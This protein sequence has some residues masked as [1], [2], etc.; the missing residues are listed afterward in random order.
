[1]TRLLATAGTSIAGQI[2][3]G[4][5]FVL[6]EKRLFGREELPQHE[7]FVCL[8]VPIDAHE[9]RHRPEV[10]A[11]ARVVL[12]A[13]VDEFLNGCAFDILEL[14]I[15][16]QIFF[17]IGGQREF[18]F[19][20]HGGRIEVEE[21]VLRRRARANDDAGSSRTFQPK[22]LLF[23]FAHCLVLF[24]ICTKNPC[25]RQ[26]NASLETRLKNSKVTPLIGVPA[27][28]PRPGK[29]DGHEDYPMT[30]EKYRLDDKEKE[31][32][33]AML[34]AAEGLVDEG[35]LQDVAKFLHDTTALVHEALE[36]KKRA[37]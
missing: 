21:F 7:V 28:V 6:L 25:L 31:S 22:L 35:D 36:Q 32:L 29:P 18:V 23:K 34:A 16:R 15:L 33:K 8:D 3:S 27:K 5:V 14:A 24:H 10:A 4:P 1:M 9:V 12:V 13:L 20:N 37:A 2:V 30:R 26:R 11:R 17:H 19:D